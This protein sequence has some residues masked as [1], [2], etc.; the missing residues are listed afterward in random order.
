MLH[1]STR[2][3]TTPHRPCGDI[4]RVLNHGRPLRALGGIWG[5]VDDRSTSSSPRPAL[6]PLH[7]Y[8]FLESS[9]GAS[10]TIILPPGQTFPSTPQTHTTHYKP[11]TRRGSEG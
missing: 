10:T 4:I 7:L 8:P 2:S 9:S 1:P 6:L 11:R 3:T 5:R